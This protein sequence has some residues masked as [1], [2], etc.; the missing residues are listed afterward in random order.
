MAHKLNQRKS[1]NQVRI[2]GGNW[3]RRILSFPDTPELRPTPDRV[4]ET[5][6][7][8]LQY[9]VMGL[10]CLDAFAGSGALGFEALSRGA[11]SVTAVEQN[12]SL[13]KQLQLNAATLDASNMHV[14]HGAFE[15]VVNDL[16]G[17]AF[18]LIFLD[19]PFGKNEV[20]SSLD[21]L[22]QHHCLAIYALIYIETELASLQWPEALHCLKK[23][24]AGA[25][26]FFLLQYN[27]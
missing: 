21:L 9:D 2:I 12:L 10:N 24:K 4:R 14:I 27:T 23:S 16:S 25:V 3:R 5:L 8:W 19:P 7:N 15:R 22:E 18:D 1:N 13:I 6:F 20:L 26:H 17:K 11:G